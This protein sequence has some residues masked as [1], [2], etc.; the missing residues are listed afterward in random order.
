[1]SENF[2]NALQNLNTDPPGYVVRLRQ[3]VPPGSWTLAFSVEE[4]ERAGG[5]GI[6]SRPFIRVDFRF[7]ILPRGNSYYVCRHNN[8]HTR[9]EATARWVE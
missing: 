7:V 1:M 2:G 6:A 4:R 5:W 8:C 9:V 3:A